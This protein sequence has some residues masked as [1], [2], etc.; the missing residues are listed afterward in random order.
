MPP[1][2]KRRLPKK[3]NTDVKITSTLSKII[4]EGTQQLLN[5]ENNQNIQVIEKPR[6]VR[7]SNSSLYSALAEG[8]NNNTNAH[9]TIELNSE[10]SDMSMASVS[11]RNKPFVNYLQ[12]FSITNGSVPRESVQQAIVRW[13]ELTAEQQEEYNPENYVL[14][15]C[16]Q[17]HNRDEILN[18]VTLHP[19]YATTKKMQNAFNESSTS[20]NSAKKISSQRIR[21]TIKRLTRKPRAVVNPRKST[22]K[23]EGRLIYSGSAYNNF[24]R[25]TRLANPGLMIVEKASLWRKMT[26]AERDLYRSVSKPRR[27]KTKACKRENKRKTSR[28]TQIPESDLNFSNKDFNF[29]HNCQLEVWNESQNS[30]ED[31]NRSWFK[32]GYIAKAL[33]KVKSIFN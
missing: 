31:A 9:G 10:I 5:S 24:L 15:L 27:Q 19:V 8:H 26:P 14:K 20:M 4:M 2:S 12:D 3:S 29:Q 28:S 23:A 21:K 33:G 1:V 22:K 7:Y 32:F 11:V 25:K 18:A 17:V 30:L 13:N 6:L 16:D